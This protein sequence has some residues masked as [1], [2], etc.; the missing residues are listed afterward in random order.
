[1]L[2]VF[3]DESFAKV[4]LDEDIKLAKIEWRKACTPEEY[5]KCF[6]VLLEYQQKTPV[7]YFMSDIRNQGVVNPENR[8]W[9]ET[10]AL[11]RAIKQG[12][13]KGCAIISGNIFKKYYINMILQATNKFGLPFKAFE[14]EAEAIK[15]LKSS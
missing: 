8:K 5:K 12:L 6:M 13:K 7:S 10:E 14:S 9:F 15:W 2:K 4:T 1:M 11:P 3:I